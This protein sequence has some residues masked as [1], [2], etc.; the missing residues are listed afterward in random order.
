[1]ES[2][3]G[4]HRRKDQSQP[5]EKRKVM[6]TRRKRW[7]QP[8]ERKAGAVPGY[9]SRC[10]GESEEVRYKIH[11]SAGYGSHIHPGTFKCL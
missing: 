10:V 7:A 8:V 4:E 3:P 6:G 2:Q 1:M 5:G 11:I 9:G